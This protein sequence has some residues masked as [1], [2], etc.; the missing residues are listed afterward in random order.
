M[1][2]HFCLVIGFFL[3]SIITRAQDLEKIKSLDPE[4]AI[5][6][7]LSEPLIYVGSFIP[8]DSSSKIPACLYRNSQVTVMYRYCT[9][10]EAPA[11]SITIH[12]VDVSYGHIEIYAEADGRPM[13]EV[14]RKDYLSYQWKVFTFPNGP[15]Y[16]VNLSAAKYKIYNQEMGQSYVYACFVNQYYDDTEPGVV[17][18][19]DYDYLKPEWSVKALDFWNQPSDRW[20]KLQLLMRQQ[21][22]P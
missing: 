2:K 15:N 11:V 13:S 8:Y 6:M 5:E 19:K 7:V 16:D 17:C 9:K 18:R 1:K 10:Q 4:V 14:S 12:P 21:K 3:V 22:M 20:Y